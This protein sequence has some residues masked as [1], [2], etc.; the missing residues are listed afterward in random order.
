MPT[1]FK[2]NEDKCKLIILSKQENNSTLSLG[3]EVI[4]SSRSEKL[5]GITI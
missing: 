1:M 4:T 2:L 5:L 3:N